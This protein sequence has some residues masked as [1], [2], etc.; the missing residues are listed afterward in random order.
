MDSISLFA[1]LLFLGAFIAMFFIP[2]NPMMK[3]IFGVIIGFV[4]IYIYMGQGL[5]SNKNGGRKIK[6]Y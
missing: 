3:I 5:F 4:I 6:Y 2:T 1:F